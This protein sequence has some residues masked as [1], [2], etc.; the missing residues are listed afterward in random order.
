MTWLLKRSGHGELLI[1]SGLLLP[2]AT[3]E[4]FEMVDLKGDLGALFVGVLLAGTKKADELSK[5]LFSFKE[6][7]LVTFF[8]SIGLRG[9]PSLD[10]LLIAIVLVLLL[11]LKAAF[12]YHLLT[13]LNVMA[14]PATF[15]TLSLS[16]YSEFGLI[17]G[18]LAASKGWI[19][20]DWL[21]VFALALS[22]S[23]VITAPAYMRA[24]RIFE[25]LAGWLH[26][27]ERES[28]RPPAVYLHDKPILIVGMGRMG[29]ATARQI[30]SILPKGVIGL[31]FDS[32]HRRA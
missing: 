21:L 1:L 9:D 31:D 20:P 30:E 8:L 26:R 6:F 3:F 12:F 10:M 27:F 22:I 4:L 18:A 5:L 19:S 25:R 29:T 13:R 32:D 24:E 17:V 15:T 28:A 2:L 7:L 14:R 16:N 23:Y 11:P